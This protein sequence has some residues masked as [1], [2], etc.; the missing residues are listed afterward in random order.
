MPLP[1]GVE[2]VLNV[3]LRVPPLFLMDSVLNKS[4]LAFLFPFDPNDTKMTWSQYVCWMCL[5]SNVFWVA[6]LMFML[7]VRQLLYIYSYFVNII[8]LSLSFYW[9]QSFILEAHEEDKIALEESV[10]FKRQVYQNFF[11]QFLFAWLFYVAWDLRRST[12]ECS[13]TKKTIVQTAIH[14]SFISPLVLQGMYRDSLYLEFSPFLALLYPALQISQDIMHSLSNLC[15][16]FRRLWNIVKVTISA[17]GVIPFLE[18][19]WARLFVPTV[20][21]AFCMLRIVY[22]ISLYF[23][24]IYYTT[25][26]PKLLNATTEFENRHE[27][28]TVIFQNLL[29]RSCETS[30]S[31]LG[32]T[33]CI[34]FFAHYVGLFMAFWVGSDTEEDRGYGTVA[35]ILFVILS[36]QTGLTGLDPEKRLVRLYRNFALFSAAFL[37][38][39]HNMVNQI[40]LS[41][42]A[43]RNMSKRKHFRALAMCAFLIIYPICL[44]TYLWHNHSVSPWLLSATA[45]SIE[46]IIKVLVS[47]MVYTLFII[48]AY[49][50]T[51][52]EKLDDYIYYITSTGS[53]IEFLFGIFIF[54]NCGFM[55]VFE[56]GGA[57]RAVMMCVHAY[58]NIFVQAKEGWKV[59][60]RR[61][62]AVKK[63]NML[64]EATPEELEKLK[65]VCAI[66]Y[67][68]LLTARV[69]RCNHYFHS[70]CLRKWLYVQDSCPLCH[71]VLYKP[72]TDSSKAS[73]GTNANAEDA[74][75]NNLHQ[76]GQL[77]H[78]G[79]LRLNAERL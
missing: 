28:L 49:R 44:M 55:L 25:P 7:S 19:Q 60:M 46:L 38:F 70:V 37:H 40:L 67:Q 12:E 15:Y 29:V 10:T 4:F 62:T 74:N 9:N 75:Q 61:R 76:N 30:V 56:W 63:I 52:W 66:C 1:R 35:A 71:E 6:L 73:E 48:D 3:A 58:F 17:I 21:R 34:S 27:N 31:M 32:M 16:A 77:V 72:S 51:F 2:A 57:M 20:L 26:P 8:V 47:L 36:L 78:N 65:D 68:E 14:L 69:T 23:Y 24:S 64:R 53:T 79:V 18:D 43:S 13:N 45:F 11:T 22:Q 50:E 39:V 5:M 42:S 33:S 59:F 41:L 54:F